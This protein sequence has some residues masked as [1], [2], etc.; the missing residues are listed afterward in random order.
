MDPIASSLILGFLLQLFNV[1]I[2][3]STVSLFYRFD[4][5]LTLVIM[6]FLECMFIQLYSQSKGFRGFGISSFFRK[7]HILLLSL[8]VLAFALRFYYSQPVNGLTSDAGLYLDQAR[9]LV[10]TG[11]FTSNI[12]N[13]A[14]DY[15]FTEQLGFNGHE[16]AYFAYSVF[17]SIAGVSFSSAKLVLIFLSSLMVP[18][19]YWLAFR[20]TKSNKTAFIAALLAVFHPSL[21]MMS[22]FIQGPEVTSGLFTLTSLMFFLGFLEKDK[23]RFLLLSS[24]LASLAVLCWSQNFYVLVVV[25]PLIPLLLSHKHAL[26]DNLKKT[27]FLV[28]VVGFTVIVMR[29]TP[30]PYMYVT[31]TML[32]LLASIFIIRYAHGLRNELGWFLFYFAIILVVVLVFQ[33]RSYSFPQAYVMTAPNAGTAVAKA[34]PSTLFLSNALN[35]Y[36]QYLV[37]YASNPI[38]YAS[39]FSVFLAAKE[40]RLSVLLVL[41]ASFVL[42]LAFFAYPLFSYTD[43]FRFYVTTISISIILAS[44]FLDFLI[45]SFTPVVQIKFS[46]GSCRKFIKLHWGHIAILIMA[47]MLIQLWY[48]V[49]FQTQ[50]VITQKL[51]TKKQQGWDDAIEWINN[52]TLSS[53]ILGSRKPRELAWYTNRQCVGIF[54]DRI[55]GKTTAQISFPDLIEIIRTFNINYLLVDYSFFTTYPQ[56]T[57]LYSYIR[58]PLPGFN[59]VFSSNLDGRDVLIYDVNDLQFHDLVYLEQ[60]ITTLDNLET[61][62]VPFDKKN[63]VFRGSLSLDFEDKMEGSASLK[64]VSNW[65]P[66]DKNYLAKVFFEE[67]EPIDISNSTWMHFYVKS[68]VTVNEKRIIQLID[69]EGNYRTYSITWAELGSWNKATI[70]IMSYHEQRA[71]PINLSAIK[72]IWFWFQSSNP[73]S[74]NLDMVTIGHYG[75]QPLE[76]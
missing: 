45:D 50:N 17:F 1:L 31:L 25:L 35:T 16:G 51:D 70:E 52:N 6:T 18:V 55:N 34:I 14:G 37:Q 7:K 27:I 43:G 38:L 36:V 60:T 74:L 46:F 39:L 9:S 65:L 58:D 44:A 22:G 63:N 53:D 33:V 66:V 69:Y 8:L 19:L 40:R 5:K 30:F 32:L 61:F 56:L 21:I 49:Y 57:T 72:G 29:L 42:I 48:P 13:S 12:V 68:N 71:V 2:L 54:M 75:L 59:T 67:S 11:N 41:L 73:Y 26:R 28:F 47:V 10:Q 15:P 76:P 62:R 4:F 20:V 3:F 64:I 24:L 23:I